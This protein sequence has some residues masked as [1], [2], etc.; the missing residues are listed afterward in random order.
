VSASYSK[1]TGARAQSGGAPGNWAVVGL[2]EDKPAMPEMGAR[3]LKTDCSVTVVV[4][5][6][7]Q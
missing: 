1:R 3:W 5:E 2:L 7:V 6:P 4:L